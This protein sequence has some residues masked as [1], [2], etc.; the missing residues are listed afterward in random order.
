M[1]YRYIRTKKTLQTR[2]TIE[3]LRCCMGM[4]F[5]SILNDRLNQYSE[6]NCFINETQAGFRQEYSTLDHMF[7]LK[8]ILDLFKW[9]KRKPFCLFVDYKKAFDM[10]QRERLWWKLVRDNVNGKLLKVIHSM[11]KVDVI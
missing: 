2:T 6:V 5:T 10:V 9:K 7:L 1:Q 3:V 11:Y 4:L 8:C